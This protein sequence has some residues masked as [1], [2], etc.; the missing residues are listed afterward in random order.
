MKILYLEEFRYTV[1]LN[2]VP[3]DFKVHWEAKRRPSEPFGVSNVDL[4][5]AGGSEEPVPNMCR[6]P[7]LGGPIH[8]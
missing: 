2:L 7:V 4:E 6:R 3:G 8:S 1:A 5:A